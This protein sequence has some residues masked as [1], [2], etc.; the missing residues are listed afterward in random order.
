MTNSRLVIPC[1]RGTIGSW[2]TYTCLMQLK[3]IA[4]LIRFAKELHTNQQL[5]QMIQRNLDDERAIEIADY[6]KNNQER[7][8]NSLVVAI[9][10]GD[11]KWHGF[12]KI[13]PN[14]DEAANLEMPDYAKECL[15]YLSLSKDEK[16]FALDGQHRLSGIKKAVIDNEPMGLEQ[17]PVIFISHRNTADG[18]KRSRR[19]FT[20]L[21]KKAKLVSRESI[22]ALDED[23]ICACITRYLVENTDFLRENYISFTVGSLRDHRNV[24]TIGNI[25]DCVEKICAYHLGCTVGK[26][27]DT[28][29][30]I[31]T[32]AELYRLATEI[33]KHS[34]HMVLQ[35]R[36]IFLHEDP[37]AI[38]IKYRGQDAA[39]HLLYRPIGWEIYIDA[40]IKLLTEGYDVHDAVLKI[41]EKDLF[42]DGSIFSKNLWSPDR[43][44]ILKPSAKKLHQMIKALTE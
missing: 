4:S 41:S 8:F 38:V 11:P 44:T 30:D 32:E 10:D 36:E 2:V 25:F 29:I 23:D 43:K 19:L 27:S 40:I 9:Y 14:N 15:G 28:K 31:T 42:L 39:N 12:D 18:I 21:N 6:L 34:F 3:D 26:V 16:I 33:Y 7:F 22:I 37:S 20:T 13:E 1:L 5:S 24:T 35:L 17:L